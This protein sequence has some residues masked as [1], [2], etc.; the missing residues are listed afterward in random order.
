VRLRTE[1]E[2]VRAAPGGTGATKC[3]GNYAASLAAQGQ[4]A[5]DGFDQVVWLDAKEHGYIEEMGGMNIM[6]VLDGTLLTP[7]LSGSILP[8]VTRDSLLQLARSLGRK[9]EERT[10][11][12]KE[13]LAAN[14]AGRLEEVFACGTAAAITPI[15]EILH[16][17]QVLYRNQF[18]T[19]PDP[20]GWRYKLEMG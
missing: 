4:A 12:T 7:A 17:G 15:R 9:T 13:L 3:G 2:Y 19:A 20:F 8:G 16:R 14:Q 5:R 11:S 18:G 10:V 6:F 1:T